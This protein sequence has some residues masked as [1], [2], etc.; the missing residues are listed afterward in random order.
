MI[1]LRKLNDR[2]Q[3]AT[4]ATPKAPPKALSSSLQVSLEPGAIHPVIRL[5]AG[6]VTSMVFVDQTGTPWPIVAY[7]IGDSSAFNVQWDSIGNTMFLQSMQNYAHGNMAVRLKDLNT[8]VMISIVAGQREVDYRIDLQIQSRGPGASMPTLTTATI[9]AN[10]KPAMISILDGIPPEKSRKLE[11]M[12][13]LGQA[14]VIDNK[15]YFRTKLKIIS[16]A[17][18]SMLTSADGTHVYELASTPTILS[19]VDGH[20]VNIK[21]KGL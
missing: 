14:W 3:V 11:V 20:M 17:W 6:F 9:P 21:I 5:A 16:P 10:V 8:P 4:F 13:G 15:M 1:E 18:D 19:S 7:D 2:A 12:D